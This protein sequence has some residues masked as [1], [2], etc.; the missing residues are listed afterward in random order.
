MAEAIAVVGVVA[1]IVQL[2]DYSSKVLHRLN[3]FQSRVG[4]VPKPFRH[5]KAQLPVLQDT[6]QQTKKGIDAGFVRDETRKALI[7]A[8]EGCKKQIGLLDD[9]LTKILPAPGDS[10]GE[11]S[12]KALLSLR[13]DAKVESIAKILH[14]YIG[15]LTFYYAAASSTMEPLTGSIFLKVYIKSLL[16]IS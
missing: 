15:T 13:K 6:L 2:V 10:W 7:P 11:K 9:I 3:E 8:M 5:I 16:S 12:K 4:E 14:G 1:S